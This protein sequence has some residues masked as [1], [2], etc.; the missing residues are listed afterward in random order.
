MPL[1]VLRSVFTAA[2]QQT[3]LQADK[4]FT[5]ACQQTLLQP[6]SRLYCRQIKSV[7]TVQHLLQQIQFT[8]ILPPIKIPFFQHSSSLHILQYLFSRSHIEMQRKTLIIFQNVRLSQ[9]NE[10]NYISQSTNK[11]RTN[12]NV[13]N[14]HR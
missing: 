4:M 12:C 11:V 2:C 8:I 14:S 1:E 6:V 13:N 10:L 9:Y 3:P 5:A 7:H